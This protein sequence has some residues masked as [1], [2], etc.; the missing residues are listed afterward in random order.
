MTAWGWL[1]RGI[2]KFGG[3]HPPKPAIRTNQPSDRRYLPVDEWWLF[4]KVRRGSLNICENASSI[5]RSS[6]A[7]I[8]RHEQIREPSR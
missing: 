7:K 8:D 3:L 6:L 5:R 1:L 2:G 4:G